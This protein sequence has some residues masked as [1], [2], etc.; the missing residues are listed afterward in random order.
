M[1]DALK[2]RAYQR[3]VIEYLESQMAEHLGAEVGAECVSAC[4]AAALNSDM[5]DDL[6]AQFR[7]QGLSV[8]DG[9]VAFFDAS[10]TAIKRVLPAQ[11][12]EDLAALLKNMEVGLDR[13]FLA[14]PNLV[15]PRNGTAGPMMADFT[16]D[17]AN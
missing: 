9:A 7:Q 6:V 8:S 15:V 4:A 1:F 2:D 14:N 10:I 16:T 3:Q 5:P 13:M 11:P 17:G 12:S